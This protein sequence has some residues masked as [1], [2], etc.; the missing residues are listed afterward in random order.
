MADLEGFVAHCQ[1][2]HSLGDLKFMVCGESYGAAL[3][4][5][6]GLRMQEKSTPGFS[7]T[8]LVCPAITGNLP[9]APVVWVLNN[10][11]VPCCPRTAP[12][13]SAHI[14]H[15]SRLWIDSYL[16]LF[17]HTARQQIFD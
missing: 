14:L 17:C 12:F 8:V 1:R 2:E 10:C 13:F 9:A 16:A 15:P 5:Y 6:V 7:G 11:C 3:S 4:L